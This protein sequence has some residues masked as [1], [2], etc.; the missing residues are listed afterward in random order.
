MGGS[1][2]GVETPAFGKKKGFPSD[3]FKEVA[4]TGDKKKKQGAKKSESRNKNLSNSSRTSIK[5]PR[6]NDDSIVVTSK[7][8]TNNTFTYENW[9]KEVSKIFTKQSPTSDPIVNLSGS[10]SPTQGKPKLSTSI[11]Q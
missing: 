8:L 3:K 7:G 4:G 5:K 2:G 1:N 10:F 6:P 11:I 9:K